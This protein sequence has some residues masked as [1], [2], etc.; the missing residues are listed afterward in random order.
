VWGNLRGAVFARGC[1][2]VEPNGENP[3]RETQPDMKYFKAADEIKLFPFCGCGILSLYVSC[4]QEA[5]HPPGGKC[6]EE[7]ETITWKRRN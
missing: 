7:K 2:G 4:R 1:R 6:R 3:A 5:M